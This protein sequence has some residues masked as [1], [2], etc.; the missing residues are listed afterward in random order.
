MPECGYKK[1]FLKDLAALPKR[2][3]ARIE[4]LV[5]DEIP[6]S[7][8]LFLDF[9]IHKMRG[10]ENYYRIRTGQYRIGCKINP[11]TMVIFYRVK[12]RKEIYR[13]FP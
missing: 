4:R 9:D 11:D 13:L 10:Y 12:S 5:F 8:N 1:I 2:Y 3:R 7:D 6:S